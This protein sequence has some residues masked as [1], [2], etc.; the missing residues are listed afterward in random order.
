MI[1]ILITLFFLI[2]FLRNYPSSG[3]STYVPGNLEERGIE[4]S[5]IELTEQEIQNKIS[6]NVNIGTIINLEKNQKKH[7][8]LIADIDLKKEKINILLDEKSLISLSSYEEKKINLNSDSFYDL[9]VSTEKIEFGKVTLSLKSIKE[10]IGII[11]LLDAKIGN[12][13]MTMENDYKIILNIIIIILLILLIVLV[14]YL[15][16]SFVLPEWKLQ[17][18]IEKSQPLDAFDFLKK[19]I[20]SSLKEGNKN[21]AKS[22]YSR[23]KNLQN[24]LSEK[25]KKKVSS[26]LKEIESY[27]N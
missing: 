23:L 14:Y 24:N 3:I 10:E 27:I 15:I 25:E 5:R 9:V 18:K 7:K 13:F 21:K 1:G 2:V 8:L 26:Q 22:L 20:K 11:E 6:L 16:N 17:K 4:F 19:E 12:L